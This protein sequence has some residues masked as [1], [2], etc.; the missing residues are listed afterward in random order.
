M[1]RFSKKSSPDAQNAAKES[2]G[3]TALYWRNITM[4]GRI[5]SIPLYCLKTI[6]FKLSLLL[7]MVVYVPLH[8]AKPNYHARPKA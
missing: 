7:A 6:M 8:Q 5:K 3:L 4:E 1:K 2:L